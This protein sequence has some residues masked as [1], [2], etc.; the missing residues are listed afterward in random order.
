MFCMWHVFQGGT[1]FTQEMD[2]QFKEIKSIDKGLPPGWVKKLRRRRLGKH[3]RRWYVII[4]S[5]CGVIFSKKEGLLDFLKNDGLPYDPKDFNF[6][7]G[8]G[9]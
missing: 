7:K 9:M 5:P 1:A 6:S 3:G 2:G 8:T 4:C